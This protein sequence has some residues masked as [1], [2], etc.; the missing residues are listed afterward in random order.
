MKRPAQNLLVDSIAFAALILLVATGLLMFVVLPPGSHQVTVWGLSR[1]AWGDL[2][3]WVALTFLG[4]LLLHLALHWRWIVCMVQG[5]PRQNPRSTARVAAAT[6]GVV[7]LLGLSGALLLTPPEEAV[8][9]GQRHGWERLEHR[10]GSP[11]PARRGYGRT[12]PDGATLEQVAYALGMTAP[13]LAR[14][15]MLPASVTAG[16]PWRQLERRYGVDAGAVRRAV[17]SEAREA[18]L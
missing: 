3:F 13:E 4:L 9:A 17:A 7:L 15:L 1:H 14:A 8:G 12:A 18:S 5:R 16:T 10:G 2:H 11:G 6:V